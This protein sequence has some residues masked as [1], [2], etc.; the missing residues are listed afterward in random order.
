LFSTGRAGG[1]RNNQIKIE[2]HLEQEHRIMRISGSD[3]LPIKSQA[4]KK[5]WKCPGCG[6]EMRPH[7]REHHVSN[8]H[9]TALPKR[10]RGPL[11][12]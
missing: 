5:N 11:P 2:R 9:N 8:Y 4:A 7:Y 3:V 12:Q 10:Y 1:Y 6:E